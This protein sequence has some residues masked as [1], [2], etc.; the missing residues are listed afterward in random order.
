M[1]EAVSM[2]KDVSVVALGGGHGLAVTLR[3]LRR[4]TDRLT[5]I[6]GVADDGGSS[7]RLRQAYGILPPGD[8]RMALAAL[9]AEDPSARQWADV[10]QYRFTGNGD[11]GGHAVGNVLMAALWE[12]NPDPVAGLDELAQLLGAVGRVLP[13]SVDPL[14]IVAEISGVDGEHMQLRGQVDVATTTGRVEKVWLEPQDPRACPEALQA[15][16]EADA[17]VLGPGSWFT[18]L[19]PHL[20]LAEQRK[21]LEDARGRKI[22]VLNLDPQEGETTG[23]SPAQHIEAIAVHAPGMRFDHVIADSRHMGSVGQ[24]ADFQ[25]ACRQWD[26]DIHQVDVAGHGDRHDPA[27]LARAFDTVLP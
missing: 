24:R 23:F 3:A 19:M 7:G 2:P 22:L 5:A 13:C 14:E 11:L 26:A 27:K 10:L 4:V 12:R 16:D 1:N 9:C 6:V 17:V 21:H 20:L 8:L 15:I 18:S 25:A